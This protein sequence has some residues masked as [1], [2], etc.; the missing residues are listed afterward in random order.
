MKIT[1]DTNELEDPVELRAAA[2]YLLELAGR[3][4]AEEAESVGGY[5]EGTGPRYAPPVGTVPAPTCSASAPN[6]A[7]SVA[8]PESEGYVGPKCTVPVWP[9]PED[10]EPAVSPDDDPA[11]EGKDVDARYYDANRDF[12]VAPV[13]DL[14]SSGMPWDGRI[15]AATR[16]RVAD[17]TW[18]QK[19]GV[20]AELLASVTKEHLAT[21]AV[22]LAPPAD[23]DPEAF[24]VAPGIYP[25]V[26]VSPVNVATVGPVGIP[27]P[28]ARSAEPPA[29]PENT[30]PPSDGAATSVPP[31]DAPGMTFPALM[32][33]ITK[34]GISQAA[35]VDA[36]KATG[37]PS[38][39]S[40]ASRPDM[41]PVIAA[42]LGVS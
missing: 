12:A 39:L 9:I 14:D 28:F 40:L 1:I 31:S 16:T 8:Y 23:E 29:D 25:S 30:T 22:P 26:C 32:A 17:G 21:Q 24:V 18:R 13:T 7:A 4:E 41:V 35:V 20:T 3:A 11:P 42:A 5:G 15:H 2:K 36:V 6:P 19:R 10:D 33:A 34:A 38:V 37:L 27:P